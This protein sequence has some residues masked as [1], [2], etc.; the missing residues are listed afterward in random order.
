MA[1]AQDSVV[2][3][4]YT[5]KDDAGEV[6]DS[7][8]DAEPLPY[9]HGHGNLVPGLERALEGAQDGDSR[10]VVVTP[11]DGYGERDEGAVFAVRRS[12]FPPGMEVT[13]GETYVGR[14]THGNPVPITVVRLDGDEV[15]VDANHPL[16]GEELHF[17]VTVRM[18]REATAD[19]LT[20]G[21]AHG[22]D[23]DHDHDHDHE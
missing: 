15:V 19:E 23:D 5:L 18:V 21:H 8:V 16:A 13:S 7:S 4:H 6:I 3:I 2:T 11:A 12:M 1:I 14:D 9:L 22:A 20:H 10:K 17:E